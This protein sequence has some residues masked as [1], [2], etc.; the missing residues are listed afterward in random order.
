MRDL[1]PLPTDVH[2]VAFLSCHDKRRPKGY[3]HLLP[4]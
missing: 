2:V 4:E 3:N 1:T